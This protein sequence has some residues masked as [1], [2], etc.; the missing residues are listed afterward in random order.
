MSYAP[1]DSVALTLAYLEEDDDLV[2]EILSQYVMKPE[3]LELLL[4]VL[5][6]VGLGR[7][8]YEDVRDELYE[9]ALDRAAR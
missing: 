2:S 4:G 5:S 3:V 6:L 7:N 1:R 9:I 8:G